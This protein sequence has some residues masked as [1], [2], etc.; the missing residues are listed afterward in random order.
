MSRQRSRRNDIPSSHRSFHDAVFRSPHNL[1]VERR[2]KALRLLVLASRLLQY[3]DLQH[4]ERRG[5]VTPRTSKQR[6][7]SPSVHQ[8][9]SFVSSIL[10]TACVCSA[11]PSSVNSL[12]YCVLGPILPR[13]GRS[14]ASTSTCRTYGPGNARPLTIA[15]S[16]SKGFET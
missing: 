8:D 1:R 6:M 3:E 14:V 7:E 9:E 15:A 2:T 4:F 16:S 12:E 10:Y 13:S 11:W 5:A